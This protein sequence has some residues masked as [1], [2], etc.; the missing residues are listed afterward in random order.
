MFLKDVDEIISIIEWRVDKTTVKP[1]GAKNRPYVGKKAILKNPY[2][3]EPQK[4]RILQHID[5]YIARVSNNSNAKRKRVSASPTPS[6]KSVADAPASSSSSDD[7][8]DAPPAAATV[9][10]VNSY[11]MPLDHSTSYLSR[12]YT[13]RFIS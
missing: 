11:D 2:L 5:A 13:L 4:Q 7:I 1:E 10:S 3:T 6:S 9:D 12:E 8:D